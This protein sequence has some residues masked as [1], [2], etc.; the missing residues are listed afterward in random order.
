M[1]DA[2]PIILPTLD[3][4]R[5]RLRPFAP[6]DLD[7]LYAIYADAEVA[8]YLSH[9][10][11]TSIDQARTKLALMLAPSA[12]GLD[13]AI[14]R[15][16]DGELL[17][18]VTIFSIHAESRRGEL[19]YTLGRAHWGKGYAREA[20]AAFVT[21]AYSELGLHRLEADID[22]RNRASATLLERLGFT[23]EGRLRERWIVAGEITDT[24]LYGL[25]ASEW[26][27]PK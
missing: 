14:E 11:W 22:P 5:L 18:G 9:P 20:V 24:D 4:E 15:R 12:E 19:G 16:N 6:D 17:G 3:T 21:W 26:G 10:A 7:A 23:L 25:L 27:G 13:L 2:P 1:S 8:R